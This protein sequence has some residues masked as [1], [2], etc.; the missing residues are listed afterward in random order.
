[1]PPGALTEHLELV[2]DATRNEHEGAGF[3][4]SLRAIDLEPIR[5]FDDDEQL[6]LAVLH[7]RR[8]GISCGHRREPDY[9]RATTLFGR[10]LEQNLV[11]KRTDRCA[12]PRMRDEGAARFSERSRR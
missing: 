9:E 7:V 8:Y 2:R 10:E 1:M 12:L 11:S 5:S 3:D 4:I 6:V